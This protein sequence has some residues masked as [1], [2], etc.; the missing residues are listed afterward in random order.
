[1]RHAFPLLYLLLLLLLPTSFQVV[2]YFKLLPGRYTN[3]PQPKSSLLEQAVMKLDNHMR[4]QQGLGKA[5]MQ[6]GAGY[7]RLLTAALQ[8]VAGSG[9]MRAVPGVQESLQ[10]AGVNGEWRSVAQR[11]LNHRAAHGGWPEF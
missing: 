2:R 11:V 10:Q 9:G 3:L 6:G 7:E 4:C 8:A 1:M 5:D